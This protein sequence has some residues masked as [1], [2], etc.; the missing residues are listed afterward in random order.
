MP[1]K[2]KCMG[3]RYIKWYYIVSLVIDEHL[4]GERNLKGLN[5]RIEPCIIRK[6]E[7]KIGVDGY[8]VS[9]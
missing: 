3:G 2:N 8:L 9:D 6:V 4:N 1:A 7:N 5:S